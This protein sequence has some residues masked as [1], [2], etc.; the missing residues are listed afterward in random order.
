MGGRPSINPHLARRALWS[1]RG[2]Y[3]T[4]EVVNRALGGA[5]RWVRVETVTARRYALRRCLRW[6][7]RKDN[8]KC[9]MYGGMGSFNDLVL[10][11]RDG[12]V[13]KVDNAEFDRLT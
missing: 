13:P 10:Q 3:P 12:S 1:A 11:R 5:G 4:A 2:S 9:S 6:L 7:I 8:G